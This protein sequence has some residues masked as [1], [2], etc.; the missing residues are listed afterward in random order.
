MATARLGVLAICSK[1]HM[2]SEVFICCASSQQCSESLP[3]KG[4]TVRVRVY[5]V[6]ATAA[7]LVHPV[8][9][10]CKDHTSALW[11]LSRFLAT[12]KLCECESPH[13]Q[14]I[15]HPDVNV[16]PDFRLFRQEPIS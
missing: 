15:L 7:A 12:S 14:A 8:L 10:V 16:S 1:T 11:Q 3:V 13:T 2:R 4:S 5:R 6:P 9:T